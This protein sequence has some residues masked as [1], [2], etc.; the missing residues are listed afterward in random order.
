MALKSLLYGPQCV[1]V[2]PELFLEAQGACTL[3][4][5]CPFAAPWTAAPQAPPSMGF[6]SQEHWSGLPF[7]SPGDLPNP[8]IKPASFMSPALAGRFFFVFEKPV[9][10]IHGLAV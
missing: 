1:L 2:R 6:S 8:G 7:P 9:L 10:Q 4:R 3:C 5:V